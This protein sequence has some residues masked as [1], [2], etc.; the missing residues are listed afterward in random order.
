MV[1][2]NVNTLKSNELRN[3][4]KRNWSKY[5][6]ELLRGNLCYN[7]VNMSPVNGN[8]TVQS[9]WNKTLNGCGS[10]LKFYNCKAE[11]TLINYQTSKICKQVLNILFAYNI[12]ESPQKITKLG[13]LNVKLVYD[14]Y[15]FQFR[16]LP[17][18]LLGS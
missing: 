2:V 10:S 15:Q 14:L 16:I 5:T 1:I 17:T 3:I 11:R 18:W 8:C 12:S 7:I 9:L 13:F 4:V 6:T